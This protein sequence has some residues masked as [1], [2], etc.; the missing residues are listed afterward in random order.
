MLLNHV[1]R[2]TLLTVPIWYGLFIMGQTAPAAPDRDALLRS[3]LDAMNQ[4]RLAEARDAFRKVLASDPHE[5]RA[6]WPLANVEYRMAMQAHDA[7]DRDARLDEAARLYRQLAAADPFDS[8]AYIGMGI[9][10]SGRVLPV[11]LQA[12]AQAATKTSDPG[13]LRD[14][15]VRH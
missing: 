9:V 12:R 8:R 3:G 15:A 2:A 1:C 10:D 5:W 6:L 13:P 7:A 11:L 4:Q 14:V